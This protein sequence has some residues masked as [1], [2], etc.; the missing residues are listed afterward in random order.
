M[1]SFVEAFW[2]MGVLFLVM[3]H[4]PE[5]NN[6]HAMA[7]FA[8]GILDYRQLELGLD[9]LSQSSRRRLISGDVNRLIF[10]PPYVK[11]TKRGVDLEHA[12]GGHKGQAEKGL[13]G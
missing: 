4:F 9:F 5:Q 10:D 7:A 12:E 1:R 2:G 3:P 8:I 13:R 11:R 6:G